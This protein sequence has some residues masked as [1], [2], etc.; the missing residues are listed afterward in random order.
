MHKSK[1]LRKLIKRAKMGSPAA[2]FRLGIFYQLGR[3]LPSDLS[4]AIL[5]ISASAALGYPPAVEWMRDFCFDDNALVQ[6]N[7]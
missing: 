3:F 1:K 4:Q 6:A 5:W 2:M 7:A